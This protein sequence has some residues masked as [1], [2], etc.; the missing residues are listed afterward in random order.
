MSIEDQIFLQGLGNTRATNIEREEKKYKKRFAGDIPK[1]LQEYAD[2]QGITLAQARAELKEKGV[3]LQGPTGFKDITKGLAG[4]TAANY[5]LEQ[6]LEILDSGRVVA[7]NRPKSM[8]GIP[9]LGRFATGVLDIMTLGT[10]D[11][12]QQ[13]GLI[14]GVTTGLG[15]NIDTGKYEEKISETGR[16]KLLKQKVDEAVDDLEFDE[17]GGVI[18]GTESGSSGSKS[19]MDRLLEYKKKSAEFER[20]ERR[21]DMVQN[22][23]NYLATEPMR[24]AFAN[25]AAEAAAQRGLRVR[26]AKEAMPSNI[27]NIMLSKQA[28]AATAASSE[29]ERAKAAAIQQDA[30]SRFAALGTARRFG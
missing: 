28:Q 4:V 26:A 7:K 2:Q 20:G 16:K 29:A 15:Y 10:S 30:A 6:N 9:G 18:G 1:T 19:V 23:L 24:Q 5:D 12:D 17:L 22:Q 11:F 8:L 3:R 25:R 21:K 13:G 27:Q 14:G